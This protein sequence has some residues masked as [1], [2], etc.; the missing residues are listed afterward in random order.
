[1]KWV[2]IGE[3]FFPG[4]GVVA[5]FVPAGERKE[6][7]ISEI[8]KLGKVL[9][10]GE[11]E[12]RW[13]TDGAMLYHK[14]Y[15]ELLLYDGKP[16]TLTSQQL[17]EASEKYGGNICSLIEDVTPITVTFDRHRGAWRETV[18]YTVLPIMAVYSDGYWENISLAPKMVREGQ[19]YINKELGI[20]VIKVGKQ[21]PFTRPYMPDVIRFPTS[22]IICKECGIEFVRKE[23]RRETKGGLLAG[24][25][26][27]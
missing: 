26:R 13:V 8:R 15:K 25:L 18:K 27:R 4:Y 5:L 3:T 23:S 12:G 22:Y 19:L 9:K 24:L 6:L 14:L 16:S 7:S 10:S 1:M 21:T 11:L 2:F 20:G 17:L